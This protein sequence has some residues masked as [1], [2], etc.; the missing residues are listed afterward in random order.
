[1]GISLISCYIN[2]Y[3]RPLI[4]LLGPQKPKIF[5]ISPFV[6]KNLSTSILESW[7][8]TQP[9]KSPLQHLDYKDKE[10]NAQRRKITASPMSHRL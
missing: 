9:G 10:T 2:T 8:P 1:M 3:A 7:N 6:E 4:L 5:T